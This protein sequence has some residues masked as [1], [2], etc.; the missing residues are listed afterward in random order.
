MKYGTFQNSSFQFHGLNW[1]KM[2]LF[3]GLKAWASLFSNPETK[4]SVPTTRVGLM[5][6][7]TGKQ[8]VAPSLPR[9]LSFT[10][11]LLKPPARLTLSLVESRAGIGRKA[12]LEQPWLKMPRRFPRVWITWGCVPC[13]GPQSRG[14]PA[15]SAGFSVPLTFP[16]SFWLSKW[17]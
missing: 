14:C 17:H 15:G 1:T 9:K 7:P 10:F 2:S 6:R 16:A 3:P 5:L 4:R 13:C 12:F 11:V 8:D